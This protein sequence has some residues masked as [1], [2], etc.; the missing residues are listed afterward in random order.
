MAK[1]F[2]FLLDRMR[3]SRPVLLLGAGF[4]L[5]AENGEKKSLPTGKE[6]SLKLYKHFF[7][8]EAKTKLDTKTLREIAEKKEDLK[9]ICTYIRLLKKEK[10]RDILLTQIFQNCH[11]TSSGF[12]YKLTNYAWEY[13]F[14]LNIDDLV[15]NIYKSAGISLSVWDRSHL[16]GDNQNCSTNL[17]KLH[18]SVNDATKGYVFDSEEYR[19]FSIDTNSLLKE[20]AHQALQHDLIL[21]GTQFQEEDLQTILDI[22]E[23]SGYSKTPF[24]CFFI[25][26]SLSGKLQLQIQR[27]PNSIWIEGNTEAFLEQLN[28][29]III[30]DREKNRLKEKGTIFLD[31]INKNTPSSYDLYKGCQTIYPDFFHNADILPKELPQWREVALSSMPHVLIAFFGES[32]IGKTCFAKR[33]LVDLMNEGYICFQLNRVDDDVFDLLGEY[34]QILPAK[35]K[36]AFYVDNA[37]YYYDRFIEIKNRCPEN[38]EKLVIIL[39]DTI[40]NHQGKEYLLLDDSESFMYPIS[41]KMDHVYAQAIFNKLSCN[42]RLNKYLDCLPRKENP[43]SRKAREIITSKIAKENDIIDALYYSTE[44]EPFQ[45]HY[46][47][48]L[49]R[50][51]SDLEKQVLYSLCYLYRIGVASI[52]TPLVT[53]LGRICDSSFRL[54]DFAIK[55]SDVVSISYGWLHLLRGRI[56]NNLIDTDDSASI[57]R[58]LQE[59][60]AYSVPTHEGAHNELTAV[61]ERSLRVKRIQNT[62]LLSKQQIFQLLKGLESTC[63]HVSYFW[64]QF[65]ISAQINNEFEE[66]SNHLRYAHSIRPNSYQVNHALAKNEL[67]WGLHLIKNGFGDGNSRFLHGIDMM[68]GITQNGKFSKSYRYSAHT[69]VKMWLEYAK[70]TNTVLQN[71][72]VKTCTT[73]LSALL[74]HPLDNVLTD[75]IKSFITYCRNNEMGN[76]VEDLRPVYWRAERFRVEEDAY[77]IG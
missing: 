68:F 66:A 21:V 52:P 34:L 67:E 51:A 18:G 40:G 74:D 73:L 27:S 55:Y 22:Y 3:K 54:N 62:K 49:K 20:F 24:Y 59:V 33:L 28:E 14:T 30:P 9:E 35:S 6:L 23:R 29:K 60:A 75:L 42:K 50:C 57:V 43:F 64:V 69:Y 65:G 26:P 71:D 70:V 1:N 38:V 8:D 77:D 11:P 39:E 46:E 16:N 15:E 7:S 63:G 58:T 45:R 12:H 32:Y 25:L 44:G 19:D 36:V 53:R 48:W 2:D 37:S 61:F 76:L 47:R 72:T 31:D 10:E 13:I 4:S 41:T 56:L 5:G 17:I